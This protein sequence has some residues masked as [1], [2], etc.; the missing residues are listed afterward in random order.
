M[1]AVPTPLPDTPG[2]ILNAVKQAREN[3]DRFVSVLDQCVESKTV[4]WFDAFLAYQGMQAHCANLQR[5]LE[6]T[7]RDRDALQRCY[8]ELSDKFKQLQEM[9][10]AKFMPAPNATPRI[11]E[12]TPLTSE[13]RRSPKRPRGGDEDADTPVKN[14]KPRLVDGTPTPPPP[15]GK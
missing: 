10:R 6:T 4:G 3:L 11:P 8:N 1:A 9:H 14:K 7:S 13:D 2:A 12:P 15:A 5:Q